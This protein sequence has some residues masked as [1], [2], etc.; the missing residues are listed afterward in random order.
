[1]INPI[2]KSDIFFTL[3]A[4]DYHW[5]ELFR[6]HSDNA[7]ALN[8]QEHRKLMYENPLMTDH[9]FIKRAECFIQKTIQNNFKIKD[10]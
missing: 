1:M 5:T 2:L 7:A 9:F 10:H 3:S 6:L 4:G 8:D